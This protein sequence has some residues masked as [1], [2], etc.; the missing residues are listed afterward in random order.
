M[1]M[2]VLGA[3]EIAALMRW[4][5]DLRVL[6]RHGVLLAIGLLV[7]VNTNMGFAAVKYVDPEPRRSCRERRFSSAWSWDSC[8]CASV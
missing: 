1:Y 8:G 2:M 3:V 4:R 6:R 7:G 5:I